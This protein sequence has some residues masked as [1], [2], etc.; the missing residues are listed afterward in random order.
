MIGN[1]TFSQFGFSRSGV[2]TEDY[3]PQAFGGC[4]NHIPSPN[5]LYSLCYFIVLEKP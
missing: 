1:Q 5:V 2:T 3:I 4:G